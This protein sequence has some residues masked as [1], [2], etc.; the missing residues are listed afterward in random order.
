MVYME[1]LKSDT[2]KLIYKIE[3]D[4]QTYRTNL[5]LQKGKGEE[6]YIRS[7]GL[8]TYILLYIPGGE[9]MATHSSILAWRIP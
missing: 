6:G 2:N 9:D 4:P 3:I 1:S 5:W 8:H 7:L